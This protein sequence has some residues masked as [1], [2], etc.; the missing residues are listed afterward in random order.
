MTPRKDVHL[1]LMINN[2]EIELV[3]QFII[4]TSAL[5]WHAH[6]NHISKKVSKLIGLMYNL[7]YISPQA[8]LSTLY[9][10]LFVS[11]FIVF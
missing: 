1:K 11:Q 4:L 5:K 7:K 9:N 10:K 3:K 6:N 8:I 2:V